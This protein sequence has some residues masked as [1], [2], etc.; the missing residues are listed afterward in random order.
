MQSPSTSSASPSGLYACIRQ[1]IPVFGIILLVVILF[2]WLAGA[3]ESEFGSHPDEAAHYITGLMIRDYLAGG[4]HGSPVAYANEYYKH[5]PKVAIGNWP[6]VF[7]LT[8][9]VWMLVFGDGRASDLVL[10]AVLAA[11]LATLVFCVLRH[12]FNKT[13]AATG[14]LI[15]ISL[16]LIQKFDAMLMG[17]IP[18]GLLMFTATVYF[19]RF[20]DSGRKWDVIRFGL[21]SALAILT[22]GNAGALALIPPITILMTRKFGV[23]KRPALWLSALLVLV[24]AGP[25]TWH[26]RDLCRS[27]WDEP[28]ISWHFS[29][30]ALVYYPSKI[31]VMTGFLLAGLALLGG[32]S[33]IIRKPKNYGAWAS[34]AALLLSVLVF[35]SIIPNGLEARLLVSVAPSAILFGMAGV[36][37]LSGWVTQRSRSPH[38]V[39]TAF[40]AGLVA[41]FFSTGFLP[42]KHPVQFCSIGNYPGLSPFQLTWKGYSG[43]RPV[44]ERILSDPLNKNAT[45]LISSD[46]RGEG[47]F[48]SEVAMAE[49]QRPG[50]TILRASKMLATSAWN[51]NDYKTQFS[52]QDAVIKALLE[53]PVRLIVIDS[54]IPNP[55]PHNLLLRATVESHP[56]IFKRIDSSPIVR[57]GLSQSGPIYV[58]QIIRH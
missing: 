34:Y 19:G 7:Y 20:L 29:R 31:L 45:Q 24:I 25:W 8:Q 52:T 11:L 47:M 18:T 40:C 56:Q 26:F 4:P 10:M 33:L 37:C 50:H 14:T 27:G 30:Q 16:P 13:I 44:V 21:F 17:E 48:V 1:N 23:I 39:Q 55:K 28:S 49:K 53:S 2:Q 36:A 9:G 35:Q 6:P 38:T 3:Y 58:F 22:K 54:A 41:L 42:V 32:I 46:A 5:Y 43:F 15:F 57:E 12:E 51:G